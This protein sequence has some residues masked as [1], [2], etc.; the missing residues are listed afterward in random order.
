MLMLPR[1]LVKG[2]VLG[3]NPQTYLPDQKLWAGRS[4]NLQFYMLPQMTVYVL[5]N[6]RT[7]AVDGNL[8]SILKAHAIKQKLGLCV[9]AGWHLVGERQGTRIGS[10]T[11]VHSRPGHFQVIF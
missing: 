5:H 9:K 8:N 4:Y 3:P 11:E 1:V 7:S 10:S 2:R 6:L